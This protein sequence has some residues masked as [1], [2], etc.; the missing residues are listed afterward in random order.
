M[1]PPHPGLTTD[2][3]R[4]IVEY[5]LS[6]NVTAA[7][8]PVHGDAPLAQHVAAPGGTY[9]LKATYADR[10]RHGIGSLADTAEVVLRSPHVLTRDATS[11]RNVGLKS[12]VGP[13]SATRVQATVY[14]DTASFSAGR[15]DLT[16]VARVTL[17]LRSPKLR[18]PFTLELRAD[19]AAGPLLG[20]AMVQPAV[21]DQW[22]TQSIAFSASGDHALFVVLRSPA[23]KIGQFNPLVTLDALR[24][25]R[26]P[27]LPP[28]Q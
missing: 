14:G 10:P 23:E 1:M 2:D 24:F 3:T 19:S 17:D 6:L 26:A 15:F 27:P 13:D 9:H 20:S 16:G 8:L 12:G 5:I 18:H 4:A 11:L 28:P 22:Y 25:E 7:R 21:G